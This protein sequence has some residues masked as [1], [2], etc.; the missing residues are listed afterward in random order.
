MSS[1]DHVGVSVGTSVID[2]L[3]LQQIESQL[4]LATDGGRWRDF[5]DCF[6]PKAMADYG[7]L[8]TAPIEQIV[9]LIQE[10]Q[11]GYQGTMNVVGTHW[12]SI[13]SDRAKSETYVVSHHFRTEA[14][15]SWDDQAGTHYLDEFVRTS[16]GWRI[17][18]RV[19]KLRWFR[20]DAS[21]SGWL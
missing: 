12:S 15:Q 7:S 19:A 5:L 4:A 17:S 1:R 2:I 10:S 16:E 14:D 21:S 18:R 9:A 3:A 13:E 20:S 8:G 6:V 11:A